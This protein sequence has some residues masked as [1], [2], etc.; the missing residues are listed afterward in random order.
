[1]GHLGANPWNYTAILKDFVIRDFDCAARIEH[2][3]GDGDMIRFLLPIQK[4]STNAVELICCGNKA[5][6][7]AVAKPKHDD[8]NC[9]QK[10][11]CPK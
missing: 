2:S 6:S 10:K 9:K 8:R 11:R 5:A 7:L 3:C 1:M 4:R